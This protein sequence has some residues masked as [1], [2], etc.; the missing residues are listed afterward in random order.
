VLALYTDGVT[1]AMND[2]G[3]EFGERLLVEALRQYREL[4]C[5]ALL[6]AIVDGVQRFGSREQYD[7]ITVIVAKFK[8]RE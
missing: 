1:E 4:P 7:D 5:Q 8:G 2:R 6:A 3:E